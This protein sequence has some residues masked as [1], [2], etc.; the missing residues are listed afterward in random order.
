MEKR[1]RTRA[2]EREGGK[3]AAE[4]RGQRRQRKAR[5]W[6]LRSDL[7]LLAIKC[8]INKTSMVKCKMEL[9]MFEKNCKFY[10][11]CFLFI[12]NIFVL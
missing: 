1:E 5:C 3:G 4:N 11:K 9:E 12:E 6:A 7:V 10:V 2:T 8:P